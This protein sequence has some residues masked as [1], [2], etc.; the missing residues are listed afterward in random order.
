MRC[1]IEDD[2]NVRLIKPKIQSC[3]IEIEQLSELTRAHEFPKLVDRRIVLEGVAWHEQDTG[4]GCRLDEAVSGGCRSRHWLF[5]KHVFARFDGLHPQR[6]VAR[7][8]CRDNDR[9]DVRQ[10]IL[11]A[12][13]CGNAVVN[14]LTSIADAGEALVYADD[15]R[16]PCRRPQDPH[17][18]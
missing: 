15:C 14:L 12:G 17:M 9:I 5:D 8:R 16:Y 10:R 3:A 6:R 2:I 1:K 4:C 13:K 11:D 18:P 7:W